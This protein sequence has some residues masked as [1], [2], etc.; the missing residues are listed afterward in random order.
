MDICICVCLYV[1]VYLSVH[2]F[3]TFMCIIAIGRV[4]ACLGTFLE[5]VF[6]NSFQK[7]FFDVI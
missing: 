1:S 7:M 3:V 2:F 4:R 6:E 5:A